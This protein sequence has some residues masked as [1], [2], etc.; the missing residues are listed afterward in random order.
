M[1]VFQNVVRDRTSFRT[2]LWFRFDINVR[3]NKF[4]LSCARLSFTNLH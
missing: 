2:T 3:H 4:S 1:C